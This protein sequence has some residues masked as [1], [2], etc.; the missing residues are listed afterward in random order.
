MRVKEIAKKILPNF[1]VEI[2]RRYIKNK[3]IVDWKKKGSPNPPPHIIK[4]LAISHYKKLY[5]Y[6]IL[7]ETGTY[8]GNMIE[9]QK[10]NFKTIYSIEISETFF[11]Q[12]RE[13]FKEDQ[14]IH[15]ILGDSGEKLKEVVYLLNDPAI[16]WLDGHYSGGNT[17][18]G[19][20]NTPIFNELKTIL[21]NHFPHVILIDDAVDFNGTNDYPT[22]QEVVDFVLLQNASMKWEVK[23]NII[24]FYPKT[25]A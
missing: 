10:N 2:R 18:K 1:I 22:I 20:K 23:D 12:A 8:L 6:K 16:F 5:N 17:S 19:E 11:Q 25:N 4:Q 24:S 7:V 13:R 3:I 21:D 15:L 14:H 9:A